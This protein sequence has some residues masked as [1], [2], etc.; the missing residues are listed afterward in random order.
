MNV[1]LRAKARA[2]LVVGAEFYDAQKLG[3]GDYFVDR[4]FTDL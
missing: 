4:I 3:L 2:D 1:E